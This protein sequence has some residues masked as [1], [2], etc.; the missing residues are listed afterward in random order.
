MNMDK[1]QE[2]REASATLLNQA[3]EEL[4]TGDTRQASDKGWG[5]T[6]QLLKAIAEKR[7]EE[8]QDH[9]SI[10]QMLFKVSRESSDEQ[11]AARMRTLFRAASDLHTN[12][13]EN[14]GHCR[15][16]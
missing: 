6:A 4:A 11:A 8:H 3:Y 2:Y 9:K 16:G 13:Y 7:G 15:N 1:V 14:W 10:R 5:A 12:W